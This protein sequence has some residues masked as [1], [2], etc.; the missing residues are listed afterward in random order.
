MT[1][2]TGGGTPSGD[3]EKDIARLLLVER[4]SPK[5]EELAALAAVLM[6]RVAA[7]SRTDEERAGARRTRASWRRHEP[8]YE[9]PRTWRGTGR[10]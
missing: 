6:F 4:G 8:G 9:N 2:T 5:P 7:A 3:R 1:R 10:G